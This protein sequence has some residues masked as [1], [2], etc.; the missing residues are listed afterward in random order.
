[1]PKMKPLIK[2]RIDNKIRFILNNY[3]LDFAN[4]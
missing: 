3:N 1:M 2:N 4:S